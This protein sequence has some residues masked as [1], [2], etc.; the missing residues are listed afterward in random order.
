MIRYKV[1]D[2]LYLL[3]HEAPRG[4]TTGKKRIFDFL[5][6]DADAF[7]DSYPGV[8]D[9][10]RPSNR[11]CCGINAYTVIKNIERGRNQVIN[12]KISKRNRSNLNRYKNGG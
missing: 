7:Y 9:Q 1:K 8:A 10:N 3:L 11:W 5:V 12:A 6:V 4:F 2:Y